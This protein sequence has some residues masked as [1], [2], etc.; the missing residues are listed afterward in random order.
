VLSGFPDDTF[1]PE[2]PVTRGQLLA[3]LWRY[4][5]K[6]TGFPASTFPDQTDA[7]RGPL[8]WAQANDVLQG[9]RGDEFQ[10][11][12]P[13]D[14]AQAAAW[15]RAT[16]DFLHPPAPPATTVPPDTTVPPTTVPPATTV[17]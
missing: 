8:R 15:L 16:W 6:P 17:P 2:Q 14:R 4:A 11:D 1:R 9:I 12:K 10:R 5:G 3:S 13:V 7:L